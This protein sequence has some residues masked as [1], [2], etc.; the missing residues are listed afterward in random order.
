MKE[1]CDFPAFTAYRLD[2]C[3]L[4]VELKK[5]KKLT[6]K[7]VTQ[8]FECYDKVGG[9]K[10]VY[11]LVTFNGFIPMSN[12]AMAEAKKQSKKNRSA[13]TAYVVA[14]VALRMGI[15]FFMNFYRPSFPISIFRTK[16]DALAWLDAQKKAN[17]N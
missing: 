16:T 8:I 1:K 2:A 14:N 15:N 17:R 10:K 12:D 3:V 4:H 11:V 6:A 13:A 9:G 7:D 5:V